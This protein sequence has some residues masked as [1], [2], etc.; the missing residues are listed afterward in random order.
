M[1]QVRV[2]IGVLI[3]NTSGKILLGKRCGKHSPGVYATPGGHLE[4]NESWEKCAK[5]EVREEVGSDLDI[6]NVKFFH[7][8]NA[9]YPKENKH[10]VT[11]FMKCQSR[12]GFARNIEPDKC[13]GWDWYYPYHLPQ[14]LMES[15]KLLLEEKKL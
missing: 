11:I 9:L 10:Y 7:V 14:P 8:V 3:Y 6:R 5:R 2:G 13:E 4:M 1:N 15:I 12:Y